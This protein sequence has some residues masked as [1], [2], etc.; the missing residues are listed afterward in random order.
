MPS[1]TV[2][3]DRAPA[4]AAKLGLVPPLLPTLVAEPPA[5]DGWLHEIKHDGY[6]TLVVV[7]GGR[8][9]VYT[10][11]GNDWTDRYAPIAEHA[12]KLPCKA[13]ILDGEAVVQ[14]ARGIADFHALR[15]AIERGGRGIVFFAFDLLHL[16][17][18]GLRGR[19]LEERR[20]LLR[21][22]LRDAQA[23]SPIQFSDHFEGDAPAFFAAA[24]ETGL[25]GIVSKRKGSRYR[26]GASRHW[27]KAK[28][29]VESEFIV[30]GAEPNRGGAPYALL[31]R[32]E[33][34]GLVYAGA[35]FVTLPAEARER[36]WTLRASRLSLGRVVLRSHRRRLQP[37]P[38]P[39]AVGGGMRLTDNVHR[40]ADPDAHHLRRRSLNPFANPTTSDCTYGFLGSLL[41]PQ[42]PSTRG[43][44]A[45][46]FE[47]A[48]PW[49]DL[50]PEVS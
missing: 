16:D 47:T 26:S 37:D 15:S 17:G 18:A 6:R 13:A 43:G 45:A 1:R 42:M 2:A 7:Q 22:L 35:A 36:F 28:C 21:K 12:L 9:R 24:Q 40:N 34:A 4:R 11:R 20:E 8:A 31:A 41:V 48:R 33:P 23:H 44:A 29:E 38:H 27:L 32:E 10:R 19:P 46:A 49:S 5:G 30:V 25:E 3:N 50:R 39:Q 14:D